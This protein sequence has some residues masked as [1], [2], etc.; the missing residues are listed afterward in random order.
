MMHDVDRRGDTKPHVVAIVAFV[1]CL[2]NVGGYV[3]AV[4]SRGQGPRLA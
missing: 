3:S 1:R 4:I 2:V